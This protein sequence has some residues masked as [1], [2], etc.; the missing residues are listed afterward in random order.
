MED[1][2]ERGSHF[3]LMPRGHAEVLMDRIA[4]VEAASGMSISE[5]DRFAVTVGPG[6]FTGVRVGLAAAKAFALAAQKPLVG[7]STLQALAAQVSGDGRQA[8][9]VAVDARRDQIYFQIFDAALGA[10]TEPSAL[11]ASAAVESIDAVMAKHEEIVLI[12]SGRARVA[13][14]VRSAEGM[15]VDP[16]P[17]QPSALDVARIAEK[18]PAPNPQTPVMPL[19]LRPPDA[20]PQ[21]LSGFAK[22]MRHDRV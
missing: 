22:K 6:T 20:K 18:I 9:A 2:T 15:T 5:A 21:K 19:Y 10:L 7:V 14:L 17:R 16:T 3:E 1:G 13:D 8:I 12:G 11:E 4:Q